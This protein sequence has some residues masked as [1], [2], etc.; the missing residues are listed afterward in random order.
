MHQLR[1]D[2]RDI[3]RAPRLALSLQRIWIQFLGVIVGFLGYLIMTYLSLLTAGVNLSVAWK[4]Y[5]LLPCLLPESHRWYAIIIFAIGVL[6]LVG[7]YL[8]SATAVARATYM[9]LKENHFYTWTEAFRF[10]FKKAASILMSPVA[11]ILI[12]VMFLVGGAIIGLLGKIPF[13]GEFGLTLFTPVWFFSALLVVFFVIIFVLT[14]LLAPAIIATT[15]GDAF[16]V[17]FQ[18]FSVLWNQPWRLVLYEALTGALSVAG[19]LVMAFLFKKAFIVMDRLFSATMGGDYVNISAQAL[20]VLNV[21]LIHSVTWANALLKN[22]AGQFYFNREFDPLSLPHGYQ[23]AAAYIFAF[24]L[25]LLGA[26]VV[27]YG[28]ATLNVGTT[29]SYVVLRKKKDDENLLERKDYEEEEEEAASA[30]S[31]TK[32]PATGEKPSTEAATK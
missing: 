25:L 32:E 31:A 2:I 17:V 4:K 3:L 8:I 14:L 27:A 21:L 16:E 26:T 29:I 19:L 12:I 30:E 18:S 28:L 22:W 15:D 20:Y 7:V 5:G 13:V 10:A 9:V 1:F 6:W 24:W 11:V 23:Y